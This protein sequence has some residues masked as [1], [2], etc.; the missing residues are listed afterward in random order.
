MK[1]QPLQ[2]NETDLVIRKVAKDEGIPMHLLLLADPSERNILTYIQKGEVYVA[3]K[4]EVIG[5]YVLNITPPHKAEIMNIAVVENQ[6][7]KGIGKA[8]IYHAIQRARLIGV[9]SIE[10]GTGN[11]SFQQLALY[12]KCGFRMKEILH[13]YFVDNYDQLIFENGIQCLDMVKLRLEL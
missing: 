10:I 5:V 3:L 4:E 6:Q 2:I 7:G 8:L 13:N 9:A 11:S 1:K 12:Q